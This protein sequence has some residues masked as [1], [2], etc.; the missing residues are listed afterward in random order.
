M[1]QKCFKKG[2]WVYVMTSSV[3]GYF[4][5][6]FLSILSARSCCKSSLGCKVGEGGSRMCS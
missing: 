5:F 3:L 6:F 1:G 2:G 4:S